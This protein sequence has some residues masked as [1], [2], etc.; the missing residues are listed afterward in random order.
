MKIYETLFKTRSI[1]RKIDT[2]I[3]HCAA[4]STNSDV[5]TEEI[6]HW[7]IHDRH[8]RDI[9]YHYIVDP[10]GIIHLG[11]PLNEM[12]A[13]CKGHNATSIGICYIGGLDSQGK[14]TDTRTPLQQLAIKHLIALLVNEFK[15]YDVLGHR[16]LSPDINGDGQIT[17]VD[18]IKM[19]PCYDAHMEWLLYLREMAVVS[20]NYV[21]AQGHGGEPI[22]PE[23]QNLC[24]AAEEYLKV[25]WG[26]ETGEALMMDEGMT[27][28][29]I[30]N[31]NDGNPVPPAPDFP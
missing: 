5:T 1:T 21:H 7:H 19:C 11:R 17:S 6:A 20:R 15:I 16:D 24:A 22:T 14:P 30:M 18:W 2:I 27:C 25:E 4:T 10:K 9:G 31:E 29:A 3:V 8:F 28:S 12:G 23:L 13:H 26:G